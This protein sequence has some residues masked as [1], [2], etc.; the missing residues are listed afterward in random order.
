MSLTRRLFLTKSAAAGAAT[1]VAPVA[2]EAAVPEMTARE[3]AM[4]LMEEL[5]RLVLADG[6]SEATIIVC[7]QRYGGVASYDHG[8][9]MAL[10]PGKKWGNIGGMFAEEG[11]AK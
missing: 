4:W 8:K 5:E 2:A 3:R 1:V 9:S 10:H 7:G 6:A 11:G